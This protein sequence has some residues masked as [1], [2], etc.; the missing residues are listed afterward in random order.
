MTNLDTVP[1]PR[2]RCGHC[3][4][5]HPSVAAVRQCSQAPVDDPFRRST[6]DQERAQEE[7]EAARV[8]TRRAPAEE[9]MYRKDGVIYKVQIAVHGSRKPYA[10]ALVPH[11]TVAGQPRP[12][13]HFQYT[14]GAVRELGPEHKLTL[15]QAKEFGALYGTCCV[16][17]KTLTDEK[18]IA[19]GIGPVCARK[20]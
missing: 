10:K 13:W 16:C 9:G 7:A 15:E 2:I 11:D 3:K 12:P 5:Y 14:P 18:S 4:G 17:G 1:L 20:F 6:S 19:A 8:P